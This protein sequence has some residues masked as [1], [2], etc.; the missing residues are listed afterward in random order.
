MRGRRTRRAAMGALVIAG[1]LPLLVGRPAPL[2][3]WPNH[4]ARFH[5]LSALLRGSAFWG[6]FYRFDGFLVPDAAL[7]L[8]ALGLARIGLPVSA[9]AQLLLVGAYAMFVAGFCAL[10]R[11]LRAWSPAKAALAVLLFYG[12]ALL[13]G[14]VGY[15][16]AVGMMLGL[17]ALWVGVEAH[18]A[19][20]L[21]IAAIGA[22]SLL[23]THVVPAVAWVVVLGCFDLARFVGSRAE[24]CCRV[25]GS[26][27]W[28]VA[29]AVV[30]GL[31]AALPGGTGHDLSAGY[32]GI[33]VAGAAVR[34]LWLFAAVLL[35]GGVAQDASSLAALTVCIGA[36][37][38]A[39]PRLDAG[40]A[41]AV[42][43][44]LVLVL[45]SPER[46]GSGSLLDQ[47]LAILPLVM[48]A[49]SA[50]PRLQMPRWEAAAATAVLARTLVLAAQFYRA[51]LVFQDY[52]RAAAALP[53][54]GV[55]MMAYATPLASLG[56]QR[57]WSPP[58]LSIATQVVARGL[59]MPAIFANPAQ[60]PI[61][62]RPAFETLKQPWNLTDAAH[63][64]ATVAAL[65]PVCAARAFAGVFL[66]VL[67]PEPWLG[68]AAAEALLHAQ[69]DF[70]IL[71]ACRLAA[72]P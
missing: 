14:L 23:F 54:G 45:A 24:P 57:I 72:A 13:W 53:A 20:R 36:A 63:L 9:A 10:A 28:V 61:A 35:G 32:P 19:R 40:P 52:D 50:R 15:I 44:L 38:A 48:L 30:A 55:M 41:L 47:R 18:P 4:V 69:P 6:R 7:D 58:I 12:N 56:W 11:A 29:L 65:A 68:D 51:G 59:F 34:K 39:R 46:L 1:A 27:S 22:A 60:Q 49:A 25:L 66:T 62:L 17:L 42:A 70:L 3:D 43:G 64:R 31:L 33:G 21:A 2:Q 37:L 67:Y 16:L 5:I 26:A 8:G 71:D